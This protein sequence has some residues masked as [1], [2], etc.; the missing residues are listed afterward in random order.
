MGYE[1]YQKIIDLIGSLG[2]GALFLGSPV[3]A[4]VGAAFSRDKRWQHGAAEI[5][6]AGSRSHK[7]KVVF[8]Q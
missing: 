1:L 3:A 5:F 6:A 2:Y 8:L 4:F 7:V